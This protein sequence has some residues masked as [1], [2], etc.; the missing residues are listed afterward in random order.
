[1]GNNAFPD[2]F[3]FKLCLKKPPPGG[4]VGDASR[5]AMGWWWF[6]F[7]AKIIGDTSRERSILW[8]PARMV[9]DRFSKPNILCGN[10]GVNQAI[11]KNTPSLRGD[12]VGKPLNLSSIKN[13]TQKILIMDSGYTLV[14][15]KAAS[16]TVDTV[17]GNPN[18]S[19]SFYIPGMEINQKRTIEQGSE[20]DAI[21]GRHQNKNVN[22]VYADGHL[23]FVESDNLFVEDAN[24]AS[25]W[26]P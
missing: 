9:Q 4:Y 5:D 25:F 19:G 3:N 14:S 11:C 16:E 23:S 10:Y 7:L 2:G 1:V 6:H 26:F 22:I 15:W 17:F 18:R 8:C 24:L 20:I 13:P 12:F 21:D